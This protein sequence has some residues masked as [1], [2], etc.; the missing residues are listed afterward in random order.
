MDLLKSDDLLK[1]KH[2]SKKVGVVY[3]ISVPRPIFVAKK[4][5][6]SYDLFLQRTE[7]KKVESRCVC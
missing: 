6:S 4:L 5:I 7:G 1:A 3:H 2:I